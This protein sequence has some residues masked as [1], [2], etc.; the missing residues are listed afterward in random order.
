VEQCLGSWKTYAMGL[1]FQ[2]PLDQI[3]SPFQAIIPSTYVPV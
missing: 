1:W 3:L 2:I